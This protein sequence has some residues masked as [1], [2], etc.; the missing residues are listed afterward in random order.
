[1]QQLGHCTPTNPHPSG[2]HGHLAQVLQQQPMMEKNK[3]DLQANQ[4]AWF[5]ITRGL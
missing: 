2:G 3:P 5:V 4:M 1:M